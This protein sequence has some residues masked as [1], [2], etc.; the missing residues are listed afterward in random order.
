MVNNFDFQK[1]TKTKDQKLLNVQ[2]QIRQ[3]REEYQW[4]I[5]KCTCLSIRHSTVQPYIAAIFQSFG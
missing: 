1:M 3:Q 5:N 4:G 2:S